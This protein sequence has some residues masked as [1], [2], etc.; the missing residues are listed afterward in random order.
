MNPQV[1]IQFLEDGTMTV[2]CPYNKEFIESLA[3]NSIHRVWNKTQRLWYF[4]GKDA[5][6]IFKLLE[7]YF[8]KEETCTSR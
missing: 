6:D 3:F 5:G 8:G 4:F 7:D 2:R 1:R